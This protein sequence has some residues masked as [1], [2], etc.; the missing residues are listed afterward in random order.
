MGV[1][2]FELNQPDAAL[3]A[4]QR[5]VDLSPR[6]WDA[7]YNLG[8]QALEHGR[9]EQAREAIAAFVAGAPKERYAADLRRARV[10]LGRLER[11]G[12]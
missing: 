7:L 9:P 2:L 11:S 3:D 4:W 8:T 5:A 10:L 12:D 1:A 6:L